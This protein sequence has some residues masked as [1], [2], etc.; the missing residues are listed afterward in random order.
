MSDKTTTEAMIKTIIWYLAN[1]NI[2]NV[3]DLAHETSLD[4]VAISRYC[5]L[6]SD[7]KVLIEY[8]KGQII[9][10]TLNQDIQRAL[11][12]SGK[13]FLEDLKGSD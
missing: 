2:K 5:K 4:R 7:I 9:Y 12:E 1:Y 11:I 13:L 6:L 10:Y 3:S 8:K